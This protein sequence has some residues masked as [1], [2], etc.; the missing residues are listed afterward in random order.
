MIIESDNGIINAS[1]EEQFK[2]LDALFS[3]VLKDPNNI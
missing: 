2:S 3:D 1:M